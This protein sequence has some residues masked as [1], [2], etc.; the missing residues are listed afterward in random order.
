MARKQD[1]F[2]LRKMTFIDEI[3]GFM[4]QEETIGPINLGNRIEFATLELAEKRT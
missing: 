2:L 4:N 1:L 3:V